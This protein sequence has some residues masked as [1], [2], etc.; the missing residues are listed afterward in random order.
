MRHHTQATRVPCDGMPTR[1]RPRRSTRP[2]GAARHTPAPTAASPRA[3]PVVNSA[4]DADVSR[5][6][7]HTID[8][9]LPKHAACRD[10]AGRR[11]RAVR[12]AS[13]RIADH[14]ADPDGQ[15][16]ASHHA[17]G[18]AAD[19]VV[20]LP[21]IA[22][23][24][25]ERLV[26]E[27]QGGAAPPAAGG[28]AWGVTTSGRCIGVV[29]EAFGR[30]DAGLDPSPGGGRADAS[31]VQPIA[32]QVPCGSVRGAAVAHVLCRTDAARV[33][34]HAGAVDRSIHRRRGGRPRARIA[35]PAV[36]HTTTTRTRTRP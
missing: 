18:S 36:R 7:P 6:R 32:G 23:L 35:G 11:E 29:C 5:P 28:A 9:A 33:K 24:R 26:G 2:R 10:S 25:D 34:A 31:S 21:V 30:H 4:A 20:A 19:G 13:I 8:A 16:Q 22:F 3:T 1:H 12:A 14:A 17:I 15:A 27:A